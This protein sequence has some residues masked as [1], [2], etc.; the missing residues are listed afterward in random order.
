MDLNRDYVVIIQ[1]RI[2]SNR[3]PGKCLRPLGS[4]TTLGHIASRLTSIPA[5]RLIAAVPDDAA[6]DAL[7]A[8][9]RRHRLMVVRGPERDVLGRFIVA[10]KKVPAR[11]VVRLTA[12][13]PLVDEK[14]VTATM[15]ALPTDTES[16]ASTETARNLPYGYS[17]EAFSG[18][19]LTRAAA[20]TQDAH[21]R[22][23]VTPWIYRCAQQVIPIRGDSD[24]SALRWTLDTL[25]D[26]EYLNRLFVEC[27]DDVT[28]D[29]AV[30]WSRTHT[31]P[32][33]A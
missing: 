33:A 11:C 28:F 7:A 20:S 6:N 17:C 22:E 13:N 23:H 16:I 27:G 21:D 15:A 19:L 1:A 24:L 30:D 4:R 3:L 5:D 8:E 9:A 10:F 29:Q 12:D 31:R 32:T 2:G 18:T 26:W 14:L 25:D